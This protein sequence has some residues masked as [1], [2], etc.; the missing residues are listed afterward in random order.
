MYKDWCY[1]MFINNHILDD[2][3]LAVK[4]I[5]GFRNMVSTTKLL[6][7]WL[8]EGQSLNPIYTS[9]LWWIWLFLICWLITLIPS[10]TTPRGQAVQRQCT[11]IEDVRMLYLWF[12]WFSP[13]L[14]IQ[15]KYQPRVIL[16][17]KIFC[18]K[19]FIIKYSVLIK[20]ENYIP[21]SAYY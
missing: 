7:P 2:M 12:L 13:L 19:S 16:T 3:C 5:S 6:A 15:L 18:I 10:T 8:D 20:Q 21:S 1:K 17:L 11:L 14:M 9:L 4:I